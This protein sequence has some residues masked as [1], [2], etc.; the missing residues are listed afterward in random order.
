MKTNVYDYSSNIIF[1]IEKALNEAN[2]KKILIKKLIQLEL[3]NES[4]DLSMR[5]IQNYSNTNLYP[6]IEYLDS[7]GNIY[8]ID[9][10][11]MCDVEI[12]RFEN[13]KGLGPYRDQELAKILHDV[14]FGY[15]ELKQPTP[16]N[17]GFSAIAENLI[18]QGVGNFAFLNEDQILRWFSAAQL[19]TLKQ[20]EYNQV[21]KK[22]ARVFLGKNQLFFIES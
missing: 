18:N 4:D 19:N 10:S 21:I 3:I 9:P 22:V 14:R 5:Y 11:E 6:V 7:N 2:Q 17:D 20:Y 15:D 12:I 16:I 13:S 8:M 1:T